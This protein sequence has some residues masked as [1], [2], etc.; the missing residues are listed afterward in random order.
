MRL[1]GWKKRCRQLEA[2]NARLQERNAWLEARLEE[3]QARNQQLVQ[4]LAASKKTS[5]NSS[6]PP[7]SD[8]VNPPPKKHQGRGKRRKKGGQP[9]HPRHEHPAFAPEQVDQRITYPLT[10]CPVNPFHRLVPVAG[11]EKILQQ[12]ELVDKPFFVTEHVAQGYWCAGC[13]CHH[14]APFPAEVAA[15]GLCGP[16]LTSL[17][18]YLKG[19]LHSS[20]SGIRDFFADVLGL[21]ISRGYAAK[22]TQ[23]A[24]QAFAQPCAQLMT[25]L[26]QQAHL[27][28]DETGHSENGQRLWT[29]CFRAKAFVV[30]KIAPSRGSE[31]LI[32]VLGL[33]FEGS[34]GADFWGAYR[35]YA[36]QCDILVQFC[37][38]HLVRE[39]KYLCEFPEPGVQ[40]YGRGFLSA[41]KQLFG[42]LHR[43]DQ[44]SPKA[45]KSALSAAEGKVWHA[46]LEPMLHPG[47]YPQGK[48]PRLI[49]NLAERFYHYGEGYFRFITSPEIDPTNNSAEQAMRFVVMDRHI[50]QGT[51]SERGRDV[52]ERMWTVIA[53]CALQKRS[54][55]DWMS[56]AICAHFKGLPA[57]S[58][59]EDSS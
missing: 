52:C 31:V 43:R 44:L 18:S 14:Y 3:V 34:L 16:R 19:K 4:A 58:L 33:E 59:L 42:A 17:V 26:P 51:R 54:V 21:K 50:T 37:L 55:Y 12:V 53:T 25:L 48:V 35:K 8:I 47:R 39:V 5:A 2:E 46:A 11:Q 15:G 13:Q 56:K 45:L 38:A 36:R 27:N 9:G 40:R 20:Y 49:N 29:W 10:R 7:S 22:L 1:F 28:I 57:P 30:F 23:K 24:A 32:G 41:L 6:K